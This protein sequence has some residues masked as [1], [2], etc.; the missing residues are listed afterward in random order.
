MDVTGNYLTHFEKHD[1][2]QAHGLESEKGRQYNGKDGEVLKRLSDGRIAVRFNFGGREEQ[3]SIKASNLRKIRP[4]EDPGTL[5]YSLPSRE[6][7]ARGEFGGERERTAFLA[8]G[9][10]RGPITVSNIGRAYEGAI[11]ALQENRNPA[12][13]NTLRQR[14][15]AR[16]RQEPQLG[17]ELFALV[18]TLGHES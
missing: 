2:V 8:A 11:S 1:I 12:E 16:V 15:L 6:D 5:I 18:A 13:L 3:I 4:A 17:A 7:A 14:G 10:M 9:L